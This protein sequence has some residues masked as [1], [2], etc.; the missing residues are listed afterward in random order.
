VREHWS[1]IVGIPHNDHVARGLEQS[2]ALEPLLANIYL[3]YAPPYRKVVDEVQGAPAH[4]GCG[5]LELG[6]KLPLCCEGSA[7]QLLDT[8]VRSPEPNRPGNLAFC[9]LLGSHRYYALHSIGQF[10][11]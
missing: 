3:H 7:P 11:S 10:R 1:A 9:S 6:T 8:A 5:Q 2:P 4:R